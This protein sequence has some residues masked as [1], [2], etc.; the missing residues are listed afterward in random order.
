M[1]KYKIAPENLNLNITINEKL[2]EEITGTIP[3]EYDLVSLYNH[4]HKNIKIH[5]KFEYVIKIIDFNLFWI[6]D[7]SGWDWDRSVS[8]D[9]ET[10]SENAK[11]ILIIDNIEKKTIIKHINKKGKEELLIE[12]QDEWI[13]DPLM[14][15]NISFNHDNVELP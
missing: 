5:P 11:V 1:K 6:I 10:I 14:Y 13:N 12:Y 3:D 15:L 4:I 2:V 9:L 7:E 8:D